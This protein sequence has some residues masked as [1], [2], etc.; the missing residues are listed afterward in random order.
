MPIGEVDQSRLKEAVK[1]LAGLPP[2]PKP[3]I[4]KETQTCACGKQVEIEKLASLNTGVFVTLGDVCKGC[5]E[6]EEMDRKNARIVCVKCKRVLMHIPPVVDK[7]GFR[8]EA[9]KTYHLNGCPQC[10]P[11]LDAE[12]RQAHTIIEKA[13][14][15]RM[16]GI[17]RKEKEPD[18]INQLEKE[19]A[20]TRDNQK[21]DEG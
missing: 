2:L 4:P 11:T 6:A 12:S 1:L 3:I 21:S 7:T 19:D 15:N 8:F 5:K 16:H 17:A 9:N 10:E 14:W 18:K 20:G 13:M